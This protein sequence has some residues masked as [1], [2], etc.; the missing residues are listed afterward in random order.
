MVL[1]VRSLGRPLYDGKLACGTMVLAA[2]SSFGGL[3]VLRQVRGSHSGSIRE[4]PTL[5]D[6]DGRVH[7][8]HA[9]TTRARLRHLA[10]IPVPI[11]APA[12]T[13]DPCTPRRLQCGGRQR[14]CRS[15]DRRSRTTNA[16][17]RSAGGVSLAVS[18]ASRA[19]PVPELA[20]YRLL[21]RAIVAVGGVHQEPLQMRPQK[22]SSGYWCDRAASCVCRRRARYVCCAW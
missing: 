19:L 2:P 6:L 10:S 21:V 14:S 7:G 22:R 18:T 15:M 3:L 1:L 5:R 12:R 11:Q 13:T 16:R 8:R 9:T 20:Q 4:L 17:C